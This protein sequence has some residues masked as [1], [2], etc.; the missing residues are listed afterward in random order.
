MPQNNLTDLVHRDSQLGKNEA[1]SSDPS[2][3]T[4]S[5]QK[6]FTANDTSD[7][8]SAAANSLIEIRSHHLRFE[9]KSHHL[10]I[11]MKNCLAKELESTRKQHLMDAQIGTST[12]V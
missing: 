1:T 3:H 6:A 5:S 11:H 7:A 12:E 9:S 4:T 2:D 8:K 10:R